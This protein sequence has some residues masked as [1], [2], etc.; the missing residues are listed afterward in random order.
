[1]ALAD[2]S[3]S[4][5]QATGSSLSE[6]VDNE[7]VLVSLP[8]CIIKLASW[9]RVCWRFWAISSI[10]GWFNSGSG[11]TG[12]VNS[13]GEFRI[14]DIFPGSESSSFSCEFIKLERLFCKC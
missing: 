8:C 9:A 5:S 2:L 7:T 13:G 10:S 11:D 6:K 4:S 3:N 1:M 12:E 14:I